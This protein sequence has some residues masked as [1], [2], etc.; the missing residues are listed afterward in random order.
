MSQTLTVN[1]P[2]ELYVRIKK[3]ADESRRSVEE[4]AIEL[5]AATVP[6]EG[7]FGAEIQQSL[8]LLDNAAVERAARS[9]LASELATELELL[10]FKQ[11]REGL[12]EAESA[13]C[14]ELVSAYEQSMLVRAHAAA[15]L[16]KRGVDVPHLVADP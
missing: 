12:T 4:E 9:R 3:R 1:L 15:L 16:K 13:R 14:A 5:L 7:Q 2:S 11:Q 10:H 8:D 6:A